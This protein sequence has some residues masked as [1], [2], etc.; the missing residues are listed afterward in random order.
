MV[1]HP[2]SRQRSSAV[3]TE[4]LILVVVRRDKQLPLIW[5]QSE[6]KHLTFVNPIPRLSSLS[7]ALMPHN[8]DRYVPFA[9][10]YRAISGHRTQNLKKTILDN[11]FIHIVPWHSFLFIG[12]EIMPT[13]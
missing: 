6:I 4:S 12:S 7:L 13:S 5:L 3:P 11:I 1:S 8:R 2:Q 9:L 10:N